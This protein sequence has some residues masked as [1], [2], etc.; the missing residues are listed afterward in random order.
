MPPTFSLQSR[1]PADAARA[2]A[3]GFDAFLAA[4]HP[5]T[6]PSPF[7]VLAAAASAGSR[8]RLGTCVVNAGLRD[9]VELAVDVAT[10]DQLSGG[11]ALLGLGAGHTPAEWTGRGL[12]YP[13]PADRVARLAEM[14]DVVPCLLAGETVTF[15]GRHLRLDG[16]A[17]ADPR[18]VQDR[19]PLAIGGNGR[20]VLRLAGRHADIVGLTGT[21]RT[22]PDGHTHEVRWSPADTDATVAVVQDAAAAAG[23]AVP[24]LEAL[25]QHVALTDDREQAAAGLAAQVEGLT[26]ADA[27]ATPFLLLGTAA[28]IA[29]QLA[30]HEA[31]WGITRFVVR[32]DTLDAVAAV[33]AAQSQ[34]S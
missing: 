13:S 16:A 17:V 11:R 4:D 24:A 22:R 34:Q 14:V 29:A 20:T 2:E 33:L 26:V 9:P 31:R 1:D 28:E 27:L 10:L 6:W 25:V 21:G 7:P 5:G 3:L 15:A 12:P 32:P 30:A 8:V 23:R 19:V 18:P